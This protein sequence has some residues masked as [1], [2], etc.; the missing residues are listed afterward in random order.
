MITELLYTVCRNAF[1]TNAIIH[2]FH[3]RDSVGMALDQ[4]IWQHNIGRCILQDVDTLYVIVA[5]SLVQHFSLT[6]K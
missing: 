4:S 5:G 2:L 6:T 3:T 1:K